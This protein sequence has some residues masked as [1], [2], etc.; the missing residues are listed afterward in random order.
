[1]Q[2][3]GKNEG[4]LGMRLQKH[5]LELQLENSSFDL[6]VIKMKVINQWLLG[7]TSVQLKLFS[8]QSVL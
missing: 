4:G 1:M 7:V 2:T 5:Q 8:I 3:E 6:F